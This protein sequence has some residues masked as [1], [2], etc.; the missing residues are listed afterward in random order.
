M[1]FQG[2]WPDRDRFDRLRNFSRS[3]LCAASH[4][5]T[6]SSLPGRFAIPTISALRCRQRCDRTSAIFTALHGGLPRPAQTMSTTSIRVRPQPFSSTPAAWPRSRPR[7]AGDRPEKRLPPELRRTLVDYPPGSGRAR[8]LSIR[9]AP[10]SI[11]CSETARRC[12]TASASAAR[13]SSGRARKNLP[14]GGMA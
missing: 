9:R 14:D 6:F 4:L 8:S 11:W 1:V 13:A 12:V 7:S 3:E 5:P 2:C 10:T